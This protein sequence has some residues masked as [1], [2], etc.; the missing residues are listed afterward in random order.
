LVKS[1][2]YKEKGK[3]GREQPSEHHSKLYPDRRLATD[4]VTTNNLSRRIL[5]VAARMVSP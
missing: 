2:G 1:T 5:T 4:V 3:S